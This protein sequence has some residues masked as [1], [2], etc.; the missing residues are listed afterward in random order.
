MTTGGTGFRVARNDRAKFD[1]DEYFSRPL[2]AHLSTSSSE[3]ARNSVFWYLWEEGTLWMIMEEGFNT[4]Q[5]RASDDPRVS[6]G[7][8]DFD[9]KTGFLQHVS[10]RGRASLEPWDDDRAS[11]LLR[12]YYAHLDGYV[13]PPRK[14]GE[15]VTGR[16]RMTFLRIS[17]E[18]VLMRELEYRASVLEDASK[19]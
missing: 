13:A 2:L 12:R 8:V 7:I 15:A 5:H 17:P 11:R 9:P 19:K 6:V 1:L 16:H 18:S 4:A 3:G 14:P 10:I